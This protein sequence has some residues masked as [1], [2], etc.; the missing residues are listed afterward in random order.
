MT[1]N[2]IAQ[3]IDGEIDW[4][5]KLQESAQVAGQMDEWSRGN[6]YAYRKVRSWMCALAYPDTNEP[7]QLILPL[8]F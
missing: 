2:E 5:Q 6:L 4:Y 8:S 1:H 3:L 7:T